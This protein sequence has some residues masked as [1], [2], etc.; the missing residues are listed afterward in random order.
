MGRKKV[1]EFSLMAAILLTFLSYNQSF[2][3]QFSNLNHKRH[4]FGH[5]SY[6]K[7]FPLYVAIDSLGTTTR[8]NPSSSSSV[9]AEVDLP[10]LS[11]RDKMKLAAGERIQKQN[12]DGR[13]GEG[14]VVVDVCADPDLVFNTLTQF[15]IYA[16]MIPSIRTSNVLVSDD[17]CTIAEFTLS[18]LKLCVNVLHRICRDQRIVTFSLDS[19]RP[20]PVFREVNGYWHVQIPTD[21][22]K[23]W[24]RVY[25]NASVY[26]N[27]LVPPFIMD[28]AASR[29]LPRASTWI[30]PYFSKAAIVS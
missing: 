28:Y 16:D 5:D 7:V 27:L 18:R 10:Y 11:P 4:N 19:D 1:T 9:F 22:P 17:A 30:T 20:N 12:R 23:G 8:S 14:L 21:R 26:V 13:V 25:L 6:R 29:A 15:S 2:G 24:S 3:F